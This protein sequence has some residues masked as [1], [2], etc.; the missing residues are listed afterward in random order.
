MIHTNRF[1]ALSCVVASVFATSCVNET[2]EGLPSASGEGY[3]ISLTGD[4][5]EGGADSRAHWDI[6]NDEKKSPAFTW[7]ASDSEMKSFVWRGSNFVSFIGG[8]NYSSTTVIP[9]ETDNNKA[10]LQITEGLTQEYTKGDIIWAVSPL[11]DTNITADNKV[12]FTLPDQFIQTK[13][14]NTE[15]LKQYVL[16]SGTGIVNDNNT[17]SISFNVLPAIYRFKVMNNEDAVLTV[18]EVSISGPFCNKAEISMGSGTVTPTYSVPEGGTYTIK[19]ATPAEGLTV[20]ANTTAYLYALVFPTETASISENITLSFKGSYDD[21]PAHYTVSAACNSIYSFDLDSNRYYDMEVPVTRKSYQPDYVTIG[22]TDFTSEFNSV[23]SD[24]VS[25]IGDGSSV[26]YEFINHSA[27]GGA[28]W[29]NW[30][31]CLTNGKEPGETNYVEYYFMR[32]DNWGWAWRVPGHTLDFETNLP[33]YTTTLRGATVKMTITRNGKDISIDAKILKDG[34]EYFYRGT[35]NDIIPPCANEVGT[36]LTVEKSYLMIDKNATRTVSGTQAPASVSGQ[37]GTSDFN[38]GFDVART[39]SLK[40]KVGQSFKYTFWN[41]NDRQ[42]Q[43]DGKAWPYWYNWVFALK[44][45]SNTGLAYIRADWFALGSLVINE[46]GVL[47]NFTAN[48]YDM[49]FLTGAKVDLTVELKT[50]GI[51]LYADYYKDGQRL[52]TENQTYSYEAKISTTLSKN[53]EFSSYLTVDHSYIVLESSSV[54]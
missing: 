21:T 49:N 41:Y 35:I 38:S 51:Y 50:D 26:Y 20:A 37:V 4:V 22:N 1:I 9:N 3:F 34:Q 25:L 10:E 2:E 29:N 13:L 42:L 7:D 30:D 47:K 40:A 24:I 23:H 27:A 18:N 54:Q 45:E 43:S 46:N 11:A 8:K 52:A 19:V 5:N 36:Y 15:H 6:N 12:T 39:E 14:D 48:T 28:N 44:D 31:L 33:D 53:A 32:A 17:A 16:M